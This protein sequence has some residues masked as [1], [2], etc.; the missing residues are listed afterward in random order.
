MTRF[1]EYVRF[2]GGAVVM[3]Q[4]MCLHRPETAFAVQAL[5]NGVRHHA[6]VDAMYG[7]RQSRDNEHK[8][9]VLFVERGKQ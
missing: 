9:V 5:T 3:S 1:D 8:V 4:N 6:S 2:E 7:S